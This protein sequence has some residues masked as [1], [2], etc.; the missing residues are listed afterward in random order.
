[1]QVPEPEIKKQ[2]A[3]GPCKVKKRFWKQKKDNYWID[4]IHEKPK[5]FAQLMEKIGP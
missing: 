1:V 4:L 2:E 3:V 5:Y